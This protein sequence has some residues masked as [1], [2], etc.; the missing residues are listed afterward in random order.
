MGGDGGGGEQRSGEG[1]LFAHSLKKGKKKKKVDECVSDASS[2]NILLPFS[3]S[4]PTHPFNIYF[5]SFI[6]S[7]V[8]FFFLFYFFFFFF[9]LLQFCFS[10]EEGS[11]PCPLPCCNTQ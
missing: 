9:F 7:P 1:Q 3:S 5:L 2:K 6:L 4:F 11:L 8:P 10:P